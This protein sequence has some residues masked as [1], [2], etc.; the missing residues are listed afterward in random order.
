MLQHENLLAMIGFDTTEE[1]TARRTAPNGLGKIFQMHRIIFPVEGPF[2]I[3]YERSTK[4][5]SIRSTVRQDAGDF[6]L[7]GFK[8]ISDLGDPSSPS[9]M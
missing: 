5:A 9:W 7:L 1:E 2:K 8:C 3:Q 6:L 4:G